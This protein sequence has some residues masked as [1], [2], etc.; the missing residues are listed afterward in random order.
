MI[1]TWFFLITSFGISPLYAIQMTGILKSFC[2][3]SFVYGFPVHKQSCD[4]TIWKDDSSSLYSCKSYTD[5]SV[6][7]PSFLIFYLNKVIWK[8]GIPSKVQI[9]LGWLQQGEERENEYL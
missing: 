1:D 3:L 6:A 4:G 8:V 7:S 2:H 9:L 5:I